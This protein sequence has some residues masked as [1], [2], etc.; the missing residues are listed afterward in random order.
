M[1][2]HLIIDQLKICTMNKR[3][4][5]QNLG[6][7]VL[8]GGLS[9]LAI[10]AGSSQW[11]YFMLIAIVLLLFFTQ[12]RLIGLFVA[13]WVGIFAF[14]LTFSGVSPLFNLETKSVGLASVFGQESLLGTATLI[15]AVVLFLKYRRKNEPVPSLGGN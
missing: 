12:D 15:V 8:L 13:G 3:K 14:Y 7:L 9:V 1:N 2:V 4:M 11:L 5:L 10:A 6:E